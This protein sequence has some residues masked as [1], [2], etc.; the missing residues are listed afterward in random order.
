[1]HCKQNVC[2]CNQM[3]FTSSHIWESHTNIAFLYQKV[4]AAVTKAWTA[5][6][7]TQL[8][9]LMHDG[10]PLL[11]LLQWVHRKIWCHQLA[12][13]WLL[14]LWFSSVNFPSIVSCQVWLLYHKHAC[15]NDTTGQYT[16]P[17]CVLVVEWYLKLHK[18]LYLRFHNFS[19]YLDT[20][21]SHV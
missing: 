14:Y 12:A 20:E 10:T 15:V 6:W 8:S 9:P 18:E 4:T 11:W 13:L 19:S 5:M 1:M 7:F 21:K 16:S 2:Y 17:Q 3:F